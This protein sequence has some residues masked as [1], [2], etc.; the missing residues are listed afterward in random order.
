MENNNYWLYIEPY[1][2]INV[3]NGNY[4]LYNTLNH[5][6]I[7]GSIEEVYDIMSKFII[8]ENLYVISI[9]NYEY[10]KKAIK[11]FLN[12]IKEYYMGDLLPKYFSLIKPIQTSHKALLRSNGVFIKGNLS[13]SEQASLLGN[14]EEISIYINTSELKND[15]YDTLYK[16]V[17]SKM[18]H[19]IEYIEL[20]IELIKKI[21]KDIKKGSVKIINI[22]GGDIF[23]Y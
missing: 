16:Q 18:N 9:N 4:L 12:L 5:E 21:L 10:S 14:L 15:I 19:G 8:E 3:K 17:F 1:V 23:S 22:G 6:S 7:V 13:A 20:D 2:H 11:E